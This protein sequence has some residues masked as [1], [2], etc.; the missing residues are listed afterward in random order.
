[1]RGSKGC[2]EIKI[3]SDSRMEYC[4]QRR[5]SSVYIDCSAKHFLLCKIRSTSSSSLHCIQFL[6]NTCRLFRSV[7]R[8]IYYKTFKNLLHNAIHNITKNFNQIFLNSVQ[9]VKV[10]FN[11][12][13]AMKAQRG[14]RGT[15][16]L[17][18]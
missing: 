18:L 13:E 17:F 9:M 5:L 4:T 7:C 2:C 14:S 16:L 1:V 10:D 15:T 3:V 11:L 12:E 8:I 6:L